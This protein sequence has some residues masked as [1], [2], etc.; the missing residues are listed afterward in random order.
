MVDLVTFTGMQASN[1]NTIYPA[2]V[3][4]ATAAG[5][6]IIANGN[7]YIDARS[8]NVG[9]GGSTSDP[10][11][12]LY[13]AGRTTITENTLITGSLNVYVSGS[14]TSTTTGSFVTLGGIGAGGGLTS[15]GFIYANNDIN[16]N[17][18]LVG[19]SLTSNGAI[20][21]TTGTFTSTFSAGA[22]T[23]TS[24]QASGAATVN[25]LNSNGTVTAGTGL[26]VTS[27]GA[28]ITGIS[29]LNGNAT[30]N[31]NLIV[32]GNIIFTGN[33]FTT[34]ANLLVVN[35]PI[36]YLANEN[37]ANTY[38]I[39]IVGNYTTSAYYHT[40]FVRNR[41]DSFWTLF[42]TL[43][44]EPTTVINWSDN[45]ISFGQF[46]TGN[47]NVSVSTAS[48]SNTTGALRVYGGAG[49]VGSV[50]IGGSVYAGGAINAGGSLVGAS[51]T[52]N[53]AS[54]I[55]GTL[56]VNSSSAPTN[57]QI[58]NVNGN[59]QVT[60]LGVN[61]PASGLAGEIRATND[62]TA[63][64]S[65]QRLK[66]D[67]K[68]IEDA[69]N[70]VKQLSGV[71]YV[72]NELAARYGYTDKKEQV[73]VLAQEVEKVLPQVV[74]LAPFDTKYVNDEETSLS[75][76]W[77]KTVKYDKIVPL[78]IEAIKELSTQLEEVKKKLS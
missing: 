41:N 49:I 37:P 27:G 67:I 72:S 45:T 10:G 28:S 21:G 39:G 54:T 52:A 20:S 22:T 2:N 30:V 35:D 58:L 7:I 15:G 29:T 62:V 13:V 11:V 26:T 48:T 46:R 42:D 47:V 34:S 69:L 78:L 73:G 24:F 3:V 44:S 32:N 66:T 70:K 68:V 76:E 17:G 53:A 33:S 71:T 5:G 31:G 50:N 16:A 56:S 43:T 6:N 61:T 40:G 36:I 57:L 74:K 59:A 9:I 1:T 38:D 77:Y 14:T 63:F 25:S 12:R 4:V 60:S 65:D 64:F 18:K 51:L 75:G 8:G 19:A 23:V 55:N